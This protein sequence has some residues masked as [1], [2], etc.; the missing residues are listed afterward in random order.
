MT[1]EAGSREPVEKDVKREALGVRLGRV[2]DLET[3]RLNRQDG[4]RGA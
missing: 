2:R 3:G 4:E 1:R